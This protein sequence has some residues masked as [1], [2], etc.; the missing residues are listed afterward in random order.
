[1]ASVSKSS[2]ASCRF[3]T[4]NP[5]GELDQVGTFAVC[6]HLVE[7]AVDPQEDLFSWGSPVGLRLQELLKL[8]LVL[9]LEDRL[10]QL[11]PR[12]R[13]QSVVNQLLLHQLLLLLALARELLLASA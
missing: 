9:H 12:Q 13:Q 7:P 6:A 2:S 5:P 3:T 8:I 4:W 1:M 11:L 10:V